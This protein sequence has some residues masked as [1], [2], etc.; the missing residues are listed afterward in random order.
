VDAADIVLVND[1]IRE[2]PHLLQLS[3]SGANSVAA[4]AAEY[5]LH[6]PGESF[7]VAILRIDGPR[8]ALS[9]EGDCDAPPASPAE[10]GAYD[11]LLAFFQ[12]RFPGEDPFFVCRK[13]ERHPHMAALIYCR[14]RRLWE[15]LLGNIRELAKNYTRK[16]GLALTLDAS[17]LKSDIASV[18]EAYLEASRCLLDGCGCVPAGTG[19]TGDRPDIWAPA[20]GAAKIPSSSCSSILFNLLMMES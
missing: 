4:L 1:E 11:A 6:L 15:T 2:I 16:T 5:R 7:F 3:P 9:Q 8:A 13:Q 19:L 10:D 17:G 14:D 12:E 18:R 20:G